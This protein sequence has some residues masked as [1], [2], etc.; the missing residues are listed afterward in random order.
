MAKK[1]KLEGGKT[2]I[3]VADPQ[4]QPQPVQE[5][6][7][8]DEALKEEHAKA[9]TPSGDPIAHQE[10]PSEL[11]TE[12]EETKSPVFVPGVENLFRLFMAVEMSPADFGSAADGLLSK[13]VPTDE[14]GFWK[15]ELDRIRKLPEV[16]SA[17][18][19]FSFER[20]N[21]AAAGMLTV[22]LQ[23]MVISTATITKMVRKQE[24]ERV[25]AELSGEPCAQQ[26]SMSL[27]ATLRK[28]FNIP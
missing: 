19:R 25:K 18:R 8:G 2:E 5:A 7:R 16:D 4:S 21:D 12:K 28:M 10:T 23:E 6:D 15:E 22:I 14:M 26:E 9:T 1:K 17:V 27:T 24:R 13:F 11:P 20:S 3:Q